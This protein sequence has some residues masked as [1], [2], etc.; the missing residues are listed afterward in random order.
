MPSGNVMKEFKTGQLHSGSSDGPVVTNPKQAV[1]VML[2]EKDQEAK[3][4]PATSGAKRGPKA[5]TKFATGIKKF[6]KHG[7]RK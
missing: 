1:A 3:T 2:A 6:K 7:A 5:S 4:S